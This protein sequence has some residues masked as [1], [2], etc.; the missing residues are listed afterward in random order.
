[1]NVDITTPGL[2]SK[3]KSPSGVIT[4]GATGYPVTGLAIYSPPAQPTQ[5]VFTKVVPDGFGGFHSLWTWDGANEQFFG[6]ITLSSFGLTFFQQAMDVL[7]GTDGSNPPFVYNGITCDQPVIMAA[8]GVTRISQ[9]ADL[10]WYFDRMWYAV[11]DY[12]YFSDVGLPQSINNAPLFVRQGAGDK[13]IKLMS[14]RDAFLLVF[15]G[16]EAGIGSI[17]VFD[18]SINDP[19][20]FSKTPT[21]LFDKLAITSPHS[22][23]RLASNADADILFQTSDGYSSLNFTAL[24]KFIGPSL[25]LTDN[26]PDVMASIHSAGRQN[27]HANVFQNEI[28]LWLPTDGNIQPNLCIGNSRK[29]PGNLPQQGWCQYDMMGATCSVVGSLDGNKVPVLYIGTADGAIQQAFGTLNGAHQYHEIGRRITYEEPERD[30]G[31]L[32][33]I[34]DQQTGSAG[35]VSSFLLFED[36]E[37]RPI[38]DQIY[39]A[40]GFPIPFDIPF[41][42][43]AT[44][45]IENFVDLHFDSNGLAMRR[46]KDMRVEI[47]STDFPNILGYQLQSTIEPYRYVGLDVNTSPL[48]AATA[49][50]Q[51]ELAATDYTG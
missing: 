45:I 33:Y 47:K 3:K 8:D 21:P 44:S 1:M 5:I 26:I 46:G 34:L 36:N 31:P 22:I 20:A 9:V 29:T 40:G 51:P 14:Y 39:G 18:V 24:D 2:R 17:H 6:A 12:I 48:V 13:I 41:D 49:Y 15:K 23:T 27:I 30:K 50:S 37:S 10:L 38:G 35:T 32:K 42:I 11:G 25:P 43:D 28:L 16:S 7:Y 19:A 4:L